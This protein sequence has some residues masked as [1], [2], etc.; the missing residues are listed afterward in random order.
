MLDLDAS[1]IDRASCIGSEPGDIVRCWV[2]V[3]GANTG[4][5]RLVSTA[6]CS[7]VDLQAFSKWY[8]RPT[9]R[10]KICMW[11]NAFFSSFFAQFSTVSTEMAQIPNRQTSDRASGAESISMAGTTGWG[12]LQGL[13]DVHLQIS[14]LHL[15]I[16]QHNHRRQRKS[17]SQQPLLLKTKLKLGLCVKEKDLDCINKDNSS[18]AN[19]ASAV[20]ARQLLTLAVFEVLSWRSRLT[21]QPSSS[22]SICDRVFPSLLCMG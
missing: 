4:R 14:N 7:L 11:L 16:S 6:V 13:A 3:L 5:G 18:A 15:R 19:G 21:Q 20:S 22:Q 2:E 8:H 9:W 1:P 12:R 17:M 10:L